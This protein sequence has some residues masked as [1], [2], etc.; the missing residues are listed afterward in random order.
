[1]QTHRGRR[2]IA[3]LTVVDGPHGA[4]RA[5]RPEPR[6][7]LK[8][9]EATQFREIVAS[10]PPDYFAKHSMVILLQC[11]LAHATEANHI[12]KLIATC[13]K[14]NKPDREFVQLHDM[15]RLETDM[16]VRLS[17]ALGFNKPSTFNQS[18]GLTISRARQ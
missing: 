17:R 18:H 3:E 16:I 1:M 7:H 5:V 4:N 8:P 11:L 6:R 9:A 10:L 15:Q 14:Q 12:S 13:I 2:S